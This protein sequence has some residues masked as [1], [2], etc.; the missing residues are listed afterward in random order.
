MEI[1]ATVHAI[2]NVCQIHDQLLKR[3]LI[4][5]YAEDAEK[6]PEYLKLEALQDKCVLLD[7]L[8]PGNR[9]RIRVS[10]RGRAFTGPSGHTTYFNSLQIKDVSSEAGE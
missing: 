6:Q 5:A 8:C 2:G 10:L 1:I 4:V 9:I 7:G 3:D